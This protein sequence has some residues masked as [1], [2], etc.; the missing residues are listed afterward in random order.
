MMPEMMPDMVW[1]GAT[2][3]LV[4]MFVAPVVLLGLVVAAVAL[5][6]RL[7]RRDGSTPPAR[8]GDALRELDLRYA[9]GEIDRDDYLQRRADLEGS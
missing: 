6:V 4:A 8:T 3:M 5:T 7:T 2:E 1:P 9:R